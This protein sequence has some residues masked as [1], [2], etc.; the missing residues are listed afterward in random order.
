M[1]SKKGAPVF[2]KIVW[3]FVVLLSL[4]TVYIKAHYAIDVFGGLLAAPFILYASDFLYRLP[5]WDKLNSSH[6]AV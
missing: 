5:L 4:S 3:P 6:Q 2:Y 1:L